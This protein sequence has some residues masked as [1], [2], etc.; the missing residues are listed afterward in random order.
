MLQ[1]SR[2]T[3]LA[4]AIV[5]ASAG[6][7]ARLWF[8]SGTG[9]ATVADQ[10]GLMTEAQRASV[11]EYHAYL[12]ADHD[13]DYRVMTGNRFGDVDRAAVEAFESTEAGNLSRTGRGLLLL[14]DADAD[15]VRLEVGY[16]LEGVFPDAF[17]AYVE[18][19]QMVP[20]FER[21]RVADGILATTELIVTRAQNASAN[22]GFEDEAWLAGSGGGGATAPARLGAGATATNPAPTPAVIQPGPSPL[23]TL[24]AY[25]A[26]MEKR[27]GDPS[28]AI[29][30]PE[31]RQMLQ[32]WVMTAAQMD[33]VARAGRACTPDTTRIASDGRHAVISYPPQARSCSPY[34]LT[35][36]DG[37]WMLD[38]LT[39]QDV[40]RF[41]RSNAW[42]LAE[43]SGH[44]YA[45]AFAN[46]SFDENGFPTSSGVSMP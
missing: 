19:R 23:D 38:F 42:R 15:L 43:R 44:P 30:T 12:L 27:I 45:F 6:V 5:I 36:I 39:M 18:H 32:E 10:A 37:V 35:R 29:Y 22:N 16:A 7:A 28:L 20:F 41:G 2:S 34:F 8:G 24:E 46:W 11:A 9:P 3:S 4:I 17:A 31:T 40:I 33:N 25:F 21:G 14:I 26:A 1:L 13:I